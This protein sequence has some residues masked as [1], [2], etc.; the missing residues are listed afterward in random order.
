MDSRL[1]S[2]AHDSVD[3]AC[4]D[5]AER[6]EKIDVA[7]DSLEAAAKILSTKWTG[8][9]QEAYRAAQAEWHTSYREMTV[10]AQK[11]TTIARHGNSRFREQDRR[12]SH[13]WAH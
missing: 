2:L 5:I 6:I 1:I 10:I 9:A 7:L 3:L 4:D 12:D 8:E 13:A 11:L